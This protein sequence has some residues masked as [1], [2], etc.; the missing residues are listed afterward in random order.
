MA[1]T[2]V[3]ILAR[4]D[5]ARAQTT[6]SF[7]AAGWTVSSA[8]AVPATVARP[9]DLVLLHGELGATDTDTQLKALASSPA[10]APAR[11]VLVAKDN[12]E[13]RFARFFRNGIVDVIAAPADPTALQTLWTELPLRPGV[14][15]GRGDR[16]E[17]HGLMSHL[18]RTLRSGELKVNPGTQKEGKASFLRGAMQSAHFFESTADKALVSMLASAAGWSFSELEGAAGQG[19]GVVV[20]LD[21]PGLEAE[22]EI[23]EEDLEDGEPL[24]LETPAEEPLAEPGPVLL[25]LVDDDPE[26]CRMFSLILGR[27]GFQVTTA[28]DGLE[29]FETAKAAP[30]FQVIVADLSMPRLDG[31]GLLRALREDFQ[32]REIPVAFLSCHEDYR[33]SLKALDAGAQAYLSKSVKHDALATQIRALLAPR[34]QCHAALAQGQPGPFELDQVGVQWFL[35]ELERTRFTGLMDAG[36]GWASYELFWQDGVPVHAT[37][38]TG[39]HKAEGDRAFNALIASRSPSAQLST[40]ETTAARSL[41]AGLDELLRDATYTLNENE[42]RAKE[43]LL[44]RARQVEVNHDLY[45]LYTQVGP[46]QW[47]ETARAICETRLTPGEVLAQTE[48]SPLE[49]ED[50]IRDL[51]RRGVITLS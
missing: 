5:E 36:D 27:R 24:D 44:V 28:A 32:T 23:G 8:A 37:A 48:A 14:I 46:K 31:W 39:A 2:S 33:E 41:P 26:L 7:E 16:R 30:E 9:P 20:A 15:Q 47:M 13:G 40:G 49:V 4:D 1:G 12:A 3:L 51:V 45:A 11:V 25:L 10:L 43:T 21:D 50:T 6:A 17:L 19:R 35:R 34:S 22:I 42:R 29:G 38:Q 18:R